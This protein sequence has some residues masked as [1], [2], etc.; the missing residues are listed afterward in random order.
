M[1][2]DGAMT[3]NLEKVKVHFRDNKKLYIGLG[4]GFVVGAA[5]AYILN[6]T[7]DGVQMI[8]G[9]GN[10]VSLQNIIA[11]NVTVVTTYLEDRTNYAIPIRCKET[12]EVFG[13]INRAADLL[14]LNAGN[15]SRHLKGDAPHVENLHFEKV[16]DAV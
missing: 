6:H 16:L 15:I 9:R 12:G 10:N 13:S 8:E 2:K 7:D 5:G 14:D 11:K 4:I 1:N 3:K